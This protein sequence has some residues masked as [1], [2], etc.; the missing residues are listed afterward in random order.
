MANNVTQEVLDAFQDYQRARVLF[1]QRVANL[2]RFPANVGMMQNAGVMNLLK[3]L[4][5][6]NVSSIQQGASVTLGRLASKSEKVAQA[7][8][9]AGLL[10]K[11]VKNLDSHVVNHKISAA[12]IIRAVSKHSPD[13]AADCVTMGAVPALKACLQHID[14]GVKE[15]A[16]WAI[17]YIA[18]HNAD[19]AKAV[20][21]AEMVPLLVLAVQ[22]P[23]VTLKRIAVSCLGSIAKHSPGL[24]Q[25]VLGA[26]CLP[27]F[28]QLLDNYVETRRDVVDNQ[29]KRQ[30]CACLAHIAKHSVKFAE[31]VVAA[32]L[33]PLVTECARSNE[34]ELLSKNACVLLKELSRQS[35]VLAAQ[36]VENDGIGALMENIRLYEGASRTASV[37]GLG[38][39][40]ASSEDVAM[41]LIESQAVPLLRD[42]LVQE[43]D[44]NTLAASA[45]TLGQIGKHSVEHAVSMGEFDVYRE[46]IAHFQNANSSEDLQ[47]K[48]K[49]TLKALLA[50]CADL[51]SLEPLLGDAPPKVQKYVLRQLVSAL[52]GNGSSQKAFVTSGA[53]K[54]VQEMAADADEKLLAIIDQLNAI[55]PQD[56]VEYYSPG[57][58]ERLYEQH[59]GDGEEEKASS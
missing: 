31:E 39:L 5:D 10:E 50:N 56:L 44:Q 20:A 9:R 33:L 54:F 55:F 27:H 42:I 19:L 22:E 28:G 57:Y 29:L 43:Q 16:C 46:L 53:L 12:Y 40:A 58:A 35:A 15:A 59:F 45:W 24:A 23:E 14:P 49:K 21:D 18:Q 48:C 11:V 38:F 34:D 47:L 2:A 13:L 8:G 3:P 30:I 6:D 51:R 1:V 36:V 17:D 32:N 25:T 37:M 41:T 4:L 52:P 26:R 7:V